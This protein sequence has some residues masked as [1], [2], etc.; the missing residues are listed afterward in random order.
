MQSTTQYITFKSS[1]Q[2]RGEELYTHY[3]TLSRSI[4]P[5]AAPRGSRRAPAQRPLQVATMRRN[6]ALL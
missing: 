1:N 2:A 3:G 6:Q 5:R 4:S